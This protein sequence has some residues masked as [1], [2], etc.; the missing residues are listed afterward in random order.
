ML[1]QT[2]PGARAALLM[3]GC[4][5][6]AMFH[7]PWPATVPLEV[8]AMRGDELVDVGIARELVAE[9]ADGRLHLRRRED[10]PG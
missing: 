5:P 10:E 6:S 3:H 9:A 1:A 7:T 4:L 2:R 8:H